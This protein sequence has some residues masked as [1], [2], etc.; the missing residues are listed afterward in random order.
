MPNLDG[1]L[2]SA[3]VVYIVVV[4]IL[5][6]FE[7][8]L[9]T[10]QQHIRHVLHQALHQL[11][12]AS[13]TDEEVHLGSSRMV[14]QQCTDLDVTTPLVDRLMWQEY[15]DLLRR[16]HSQMQ[17]PWRSLQ[18]Q[19]GCTPRSRH[20]LASAQDMATQTAPDQ[21]GTIAEEVPAVQ[22]TCPKAVSSQTAAATAATATTAASG[23][24]EGSD[25][26][27]PQTMGQ[28][29]GY[30]SNGMQSQDGDHSAEP[31]RRRPG[32]RIQAVPKNRADNNPAHNND[33]SAPAHSSDE[34]GADDE[35]EEH[36]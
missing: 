2:S 14:P 10:L 18:Q 12:Q 27:T 22:T 16:T 33:G 19:H 28:D 23:I 34:D 9:N 15:P 24:A 36:G 8:L 1:R 3:A 13:H 26:Q 4:L 6:Q 31:L 20:Q 32:D 25:E 30:S 21:F 35:N 11:G 17:S 29:S 7:D 5:Q